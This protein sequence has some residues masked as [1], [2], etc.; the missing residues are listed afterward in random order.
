MTFNLIYAQLN[1]VEVEESK[2][3]KVEAEADVGE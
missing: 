2:I 3:N 1:A